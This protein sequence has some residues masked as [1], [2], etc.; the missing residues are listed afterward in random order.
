VRGEKRWRLGPASW[1]GIVF[2]MLNATA[3]SEV[4]RLDCGERCAERVAGPVILPSLGVQ[5]GF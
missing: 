2:E 5:A 3:T 1:V 4:V